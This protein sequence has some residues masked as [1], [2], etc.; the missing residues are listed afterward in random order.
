MLGLLS[1]ACS[2]P[3]RRHRETLLR[4]KIRKTLKR[5]GIT[6]LHPDFLE[7]QGITDKRSFFEDS[8]NGM[9]ERHGRV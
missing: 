8:K 3:R 7:K 6:H 9:R 2:N 5:L 1:Y 4:P